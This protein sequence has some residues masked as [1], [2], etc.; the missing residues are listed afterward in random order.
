MKGELRRVA[1]CAKDTVF[2]ATLAVFDQLLKPLLF[3]LWCCLK[4]CVGLVPCWIF[5]CG[6]KLL[7]QMLH[8]LLELFNLLLKLLDSLQ[9]LNVFMLVM[10]RARLQLLVASLFKLSFLMLACIFLLWNQ[11]GM[12]H[13]HIART[14]LLLVQLGML[15]SWLT[16]KFLCCLGKLS[17]ESLCLAS[18]PE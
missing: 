9:L 6:S 15:C 5:L 16:R 13:N 14:F 10:L 1:F 2:A 3:L 7:L 12:V 17:F 8:F 18:F 4:H 11:H